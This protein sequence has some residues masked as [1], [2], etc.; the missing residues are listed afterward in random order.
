[1]SP[2]F[3]HKLNA[4]SQSATFE[5]Y[6]AQNLVLYFSIALDNYN[7]KGPEAWL[8]YFNDMSSEEIAFIKEKLSKLPPMPSLHYDE[9]LQQF[10]VKSD[11]KELTFK[12]S[13]EEANTFILNN[14]KFQIDESDTLISIYSRLEFEK[15]NSHKKAQALNFFSIFPS[16]HA[17]TKGAMIGIALITALAMAL[18]Y[19]NKGS[20][21]QNVGG[22]VDKIHGGSNNTPIDYDTRFSGVKG[23]LRGGK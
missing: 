1:L 20:F 18:M 8:E 14:K 15:I 13:S 9:N 10:L 4:N 7:K 16:A 12:L 2:L 22:F 11:D 6:D 21:K 17:D 5:N 3:S 19:K 23:W